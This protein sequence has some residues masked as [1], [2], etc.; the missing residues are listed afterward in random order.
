MQ[1]ALLSM[2]KNIKHLDVFD[3]VFGAVSVEYKVLSVLTCGDR[4]SQ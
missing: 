2:T 1:T 4:S 3:A